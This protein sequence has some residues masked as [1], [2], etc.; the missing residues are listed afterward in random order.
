MQ[1]SAKKACFQI[2]E[3]SFSAAKI[4]YFFVTTNFFEKKTTQNTDFSD[5]RLLSYHFT[6]G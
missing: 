1:T 5:F 2:A 6:S 3:S 4:R